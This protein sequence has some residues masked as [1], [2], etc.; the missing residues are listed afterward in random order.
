MNLKELSQHLG[1]SQTTVSRALNGYPDVSEKTRARV[2]A[3]AARLAYS[4]NTSAQ[5]LATGRSETIGIVLPQDNNLLLDPLFSEFLTGVASEAARTKT[6]V[7]IKAT[8]EDE[9]TTYRNMARG[10]SADIVIISS[11]LVVDPRLPLLESLGLPVIVH[12]RT[13]YD[14][15]YAYL[16]I[17][18]EGAF[19][20]A[21]DLLLDLGHRRI[22]LINGR[23]EMNFATDR[24]RGWRNALLARGMTPPDWYASSGGM[25]EENGYRQTLRMLSGEAPP[26]AL[27]CGSAVMALGCCR[28]LRDLN[29]VMGSDVSLIAHDDGLSYIR[30]EALS[31]PLTT[32][33]SSLR[34]AGVRIA[35]LAHRIATGTPVSSIAEVWPVDLIFRGSANPPRS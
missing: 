13:T 35:E 33:T 1:L 23:V 22:G 26:T 25:T 10:R 4:P 16:D 20:R 17:D 34:E 18:N 3:E 15:P 27:L 7:L 30:P 5:R 9:T 31:P 8:F 2:Q 28:A 12:G 24:E 6:D 11:P 21:T 14:R 32:T 29:L 19:R